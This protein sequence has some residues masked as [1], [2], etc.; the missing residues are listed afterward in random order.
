MQGY[1]F[2]KPVPPEETTTL[3]RS[4]AGQY[5]AAAPAT[6][7]PATVNADEAHL[8]GDRPATRGA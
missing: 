2:G 8:L 4:V 5:G 7:E 3:L 6:V 1:L